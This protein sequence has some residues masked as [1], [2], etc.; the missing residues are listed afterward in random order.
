[1]SINDLMSKQEKAQKEDK[2]EE[3]YTDR[4]TD[5][6]TIDDLKMNWRKYAFQAREEGQNTIYTAL[7]SKDPVLGEA[8]EVKFFVDNDVQLGFLVKQKTNLLD[9][10]RKALNN[11]SVELTLAEEQISEGKNIFSAK[12]KYNDMVDRNPHLK[13]LRQKFNLDID[14]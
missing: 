9:F 6:F 2:E 5:S 14:Y 13:S 4:P 11:W 10:L 8:N 12:D 3:Q 1:L 7:T